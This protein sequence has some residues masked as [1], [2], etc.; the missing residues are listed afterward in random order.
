MN[1]AV[2]FLPKLLTVYKIGAAEI[3]QTT[4]KTVR[5]LHGTMTVRATIQPAKARA[6]EDFPEGIRESAAWFIWTMHDLDVGWWVKHSGELYRIDAVE[7]RHET[8]HTKAVLG[9]L[10]DFD[11]TIKVVDTGK[12]LAL[13]EFLLTLG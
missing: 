6:I 2:T 1:P 8:G 9:K 4:G 11:G 12:Y 7:Q 5:Q 10:G 13:G 3:D